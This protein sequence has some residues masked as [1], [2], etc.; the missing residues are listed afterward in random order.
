MGANAVGYGILPGCDV[1]IGRETAKPG[2]AAVISDV[3]RV[4]VGITGVDN[5]LGI[6]DVATVNPPTNV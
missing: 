4:D 6:V 3:A 5:K 1:C 2:G